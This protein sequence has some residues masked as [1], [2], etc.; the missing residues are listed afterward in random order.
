MTPASNDPIYTAIEAHRA[1]YADYDAAAEAPDEEND[2]AFR[3]LDT[4]SQALMRAEVSTV[5]GLTALLRYVA[6]LLLEAGAPGLPI[7][8]PFAGRW[9]AAYGTFCAHVAERLPAIL[10][11]PELVDQVGDAIVEATGDLFDD[12]E[13][14]RTVARAAIEAI[15]EGQR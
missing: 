8:V 7:E 11:A 6:P 1:A 15:A 14:V 2:E 13:V 10:A 9:S 12:F 4:A 3:A 5:A